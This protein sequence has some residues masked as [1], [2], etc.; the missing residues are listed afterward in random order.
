[1][2]CYYWLRIS[3]IIKLHKIKLIIKNPISNILLTN[4]ILLYLHY[5]LYPALLL[6][7]ELCFP[8]LDFFCYD[9]RGLLINDY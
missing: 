5:S 4:S 6:K 2:V 3:K 9:I 1:M 7:V 8:C